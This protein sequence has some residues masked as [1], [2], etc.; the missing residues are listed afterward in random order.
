MQPTFPTLYST[1]HPAALATFI[2]QQYALGPV[3][4]QF[5]VRGVGDTYLI[6]AGTTRY[7][8][9]IYRSSH[10]S[11]SQIQAEMELLT[12]LKNA[13]IRV[14]Y[15]VADKS[16]AFIQAFPAAEGIRHAVVFTYAT[17]RSLQQMNDAQLRNFGREM[18]RFHNV[19][20]QMTLSDQRWKFDLE[21]T[22]FKPLELLKDYYREDPAG[23]AW[24][25]E[26]GQQVAT[27]LSTLDTAAFSTGYCHFDFLPKNFHFDEQDNITFFDF[28]FFGHGWLIHDI[29]SYRQHLML[30]VLLNRQTAEGASDV[31]ATF[32]AAYQAERPL[33]KDELA[34]IPHLT[35]GFWL[36][37]MG[38]HTTHDQFYPFIQPAVLQVRTP[39]IRKLIEM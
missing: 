18:A 29:M 8:L 9:R 21:T 26:A 33:S 7:I 15:P 10:R 27:S 5:L 4:C 30:D 19:S 32:L 39:F 25:Q 28:D 37:Y 16:G 2:S 17:G 6:E 1:L 12:A 38:F 34:A 24:L 23:Y 20:A 13:D 11:L 35:L 22:I 36:F 14:S 31:Y 3:Q